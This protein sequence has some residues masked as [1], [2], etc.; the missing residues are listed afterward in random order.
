MEDV[1]VSDVLPLLLQGQSAFSF[2]EEPYCLYSF[3]DGESD[4]VRTK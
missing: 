1:Q 4:W 3:T 2:K